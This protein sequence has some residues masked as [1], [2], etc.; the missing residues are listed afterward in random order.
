[1]SGAPEPTATDAEADRNLRARL[2]EMLEATGIEQARCHEPLVI[3]SDVHLRSSY[4]YR[5]RIED[6]RPLWR[7]VQSVVFNGDTY[8]FSL[9]RSAECYLQVRLYLLEACRADGVEPVFL[10]G[11]GDSHVTPVKHLVLGQGH[12]LVT[13]GD[14]LFPGITLWRSWRAQA[15]ACRRRILEDLDPETSQTMEGLLLATRLATMEMQ[16]I[17]HVQKQ[18]GRQMALMARELVHLPLA[19][20]AL[21]VAWRSAPKRAAEFLERYAPNQ[22]TLVIGHTHRPGLWQIGGR[23]IINTG[24]FGVLGRPWAVYLNEAKLTVRKVLKTSEGFSA[25]AAVESLDVTR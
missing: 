8:S 21:A 19:M 12:V 15:Q 10:A 6:L 20:W 13:H 1:M 3:L 17:V 2:A 7:G 24:G 14:V 18:A 5:R 11:N 9:T 4:D 23:T 22:R 16:A 25:G